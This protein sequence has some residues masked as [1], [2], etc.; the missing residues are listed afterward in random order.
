MRSSSPTGGESNHGDCLTVFQDPGD[1]FLAIDFQTESPIG[2]ISAALPPDVR[3]WLRPTE[4]LLIRLGATPWGMAPRTGK[5]LFGRSQTFRTS[6]G[7]AQEPPVLTAL[8]APLRLPHRRAHRMQFLQG[9][10]LD[11]AAGFPC[12]DGLDDCLRA[13]HRS[14]AGNV[15]LQSRAANC[16]LIKVG[17]AP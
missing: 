17:S 3:W 10:D 8:P 16:L 15:V 2:S 12:T 7:G 1:C 13:R 11:C 4:G 14:H 9:A 6:V 5:M